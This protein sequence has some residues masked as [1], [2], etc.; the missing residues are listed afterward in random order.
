MDQHPTHLSLNRDPAKPIAITGMAG[1]F[2]SA[3]DIT[4]FQ[5]ALHAGESLLSA[6]PPGRFSWLIKP[7]GSMR[8]SAGGFLPDVAAFDAE[9]FGIGPREALRM[10]P[11]LRILLET[12]RDALQDAGLRPSALRGSQTAVF[13]ANTM[14][15]WAN[16]LCSPQNAER[17]RLVDVVPSQL[18]ARISRNFDL[19]GSS[20]VISTACSGGLHAVHRACQALREGECD[21]AL[22]MGVNI[23]LASE[24][25]IGL[26]R[27]GMLARGEQSPAFSRDAAGFLRGE[28]AGV[29]VLMRAGDAAA[30]RHDVKALIRGSSVGHGGAT[31][32]YDVRDAETQSRSVSRALRM[33]G[34]MPRDVAYVELQ[35]AGNLTEEI[36]EVAVIHQG[37]RAVAAD[38]AGMPA[39]LNAGC[40]KPVTGHMEAASGIAQIVKVI[41]VLE[42]GHAPPLPGLDERPGEMAELWPALSF[43]AAGEPLMSTPGQRCALISGLG[44]GGNHAHVVL[45]VPK[46]QPRN[47]PKPE[48]THAYFLSARSSECL[49]GLRARLARFLRETPDLSAED[50]SC[51]MLL[52]RDAE[53]ERA[54]FLADSLRS[55]ASQLEDGTPAAQGRA[56]EVGPC[57]GGD[58]HDRQWLRAHL[59][60]GNWHKLAVLWCQGVNFAWEGVTD[61]LP[62]CMVSLPP[63]PFSR[64]TYWL[65][66]AAPVAVEPAVSVPEDD[67]QRRPAPSSAKDRVY[68]DLFAQVVGETRQDL[69]QDDTT[70]AEMGFDSL[71]AAEL[72]SHVM[73]AQE[74]ARIQLTDII[75]APNLRALID[76]MPEPTGPP[77]LPARA[78]DE[79][80]RHDPFPVTDIQLAYLIGR[81]AVREGG[82]FGCQV[83]W[84]FS[85]PGIDLDRLRGACERLVSRHD[86]LRAV[87]MPD[88][89]QKVMP[90]DQVTSI[91]LSMVDWSDLNPADA[92][93]KRQALAGQ[94]LSRNFDAARWPLFELVVSRGPKDDRLHLALDLLIADGPSLILMLDDL[95]RFY[96]GAEPADPPPSFQFRDYVL[97]TRGEDDKARAYWE[98]RLDTLPEAPQLPYQPG[99]P[100]STVV[101]RLERVLPP[102]AWSDFQRHA[103]SNGLTV[104]AALIA[105]FSGSLA[106]WSSHSS[107]CLNVTL[108]ARKP[109]HP[110]VSRLVGDFTQNIL[111]AVP[112]RAGDRFADYAQRIAAQLLADCEH[113]DFSAVS[114][115]RLL[116]Q[117]HRRPVSMPIVFTSLLGYGGILKRKARI[118][119]MGRYVRGATRTPQV[120][121]DAQVLEAEDGLHISWDVM[122]GWL[123]PDLLADMF[124]GFTACTERLATEEAAWQEPGRHPAPPPA[125]QRANAT[126]ARL[127]QEPIHAGILRQAEQDPERVAVVAED[128][129]LSFGELAGEARCLAQR[130]TQHGVRHG[131]L[132][133]VVCPKGWRQ[134]VSVLAAC[135][136]GA[137]YVPVELPMPAERIAKVLA[138]AGTKVVLAHMAPDTTAWPCPVIDDWALDTVAHFAPLPVSATDLAYVIYTSGSTGEPKGVA[139]EHGAV[140]N[141]LHSVNDAFAIGSEDCVLG[142]SSL[143]FDLSV[144]DIFGVLGAGGR[145]VLPAAQSLRDPH[146]LSELCR[147]EG[148]TVWNS[149]PSYL[150]LVVETPNVVLHPTLRLVM[151]SGDWIPLELARGLR[152]QQPQA[153]LVSLGG[154]TEAAIWSIWHEVGEV[155]AHW[156]SIPYGK[157]M[158]NQRFHILDD[159]LQPVPVGE[160]GQLHISG[161][162]LAR[163]YWRDA[164]QTELSFIRHPVTGERLYRT[165]DFGRLMEDGA[166]EF[167]GRRDAQVKIGGH[168]IELGEIEA[169]VSRL[170]PERDITDGVAFTFTDPAGNQRLGL[171]YRSA[172]GAAESDVRSAL[173]ARLAPYMVPAVILRLNEIPLTDNSKVD[174]KTLA[175]MA[176]A[177]SAAPAAMAQSSPPAVSQ[178]LGSLLSDDRLLKSPEDRHAFVAGS[179]AVR[180]DLDGAP[181]VALAGGPVTDE[182]LRRSTRSFAATALADAHLA[183]LLSP[184]R[185]VPDAAGPRRR[186][187]SAGS[188]Y[189]V[190]AYVILQG[191]GLS[192]ARRGLWYYDPAQNRLLRTGDFACDLADLHAPANRAMAGSA[193]VTILLVGDRA[194]IEPL[195]GA[196]SDDMMRIEAGSMAQLLADAAAQ[197]NIGQCTV[198]WM[199]IAPLASGLRLSPRHVLLYALLAGHPASTKVQQ[200]A[201]HSKPPAMPKPSGHALARVRAAWSQVL[202]H[203]QFGDD[204]NF[205][206]VGGNSFVAVSLQAQLAG[207]FTPAPSVTDLFRYPTVR[208][209]AAHLEPVVA[210]VEPAA[211]QPLPPPELSAAGWRRSRRLDARRSINGRSGWGQQ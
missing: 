116:S 54:V 55:L 78:A 56:A 32:S 69:W 48:A 37:F 123:A 168:R 9:A 163:C 186:Y 143:A 115:M 57:I 23:S 181:A 91:P 4:S 200:P 46:R 64:Q 85:H 88:A 81:E 89:T 109:L 180:R 95:A 170:I 97:A 132:V 141:T 206:E 128:R 157:A 188:S 130:L 62:G 65:E 203:E 199:D 67:R 29:L 198:G 31:G 134:I 7:T 44:F 179:M 167:L 187:A 151:L 190:Q 53:A 61:E 153:R 33:A 139:L 131:D 120:L 144:W 11:Q 136:C 133:G 74:N 41:T 36:A 110:D 122:E 82:G 27:A 51:T 117:K 155:P 19:R 154:A 193:P 142:V 93:V 13:L 172:S 49:G 164:G 17:L 26:A 94:L 40:L 105:A 162:G 39:R 111:L 73:A 92:E 75:S 52:G 71:A 107:F 1:R 129:R 59:R 30:G 20:E 114:V 182:P 207:T 70:T 45:E 77:A 166:I 15:D 100:P 35:A 201:Q 127:P 165:G 108:A 147:R 38:D 63:T 84:E 183:G 113:G 76:L 22:V 60:T 192:A 87:F 202:G 99:K 66:D 50:I 101:R 8:Q 34:I 47:A 96:E 205:F 137:A 25:Y 150:R 211:P 158:P 86:M 125:L 209:L 72:R 14:N 3:T 90:P 146:Y 161:T 126:A 210:A 28:G 169:A 102:A 103:A 197:M 43:A 138:R 124:A 2:A 174:R 189:A 24:S 21:I 12:T 177:Q 176:L 16:R 145:L 58:E 178:K 171:C 173:A 196:M 112:E 118:D 152:R 6:T 135:L 121:L 204:A 156:R 160:D 175:R 42:A 5:R 159:A 10:D 184:L 80:H 185:E 18:A 148:V 191:Q 208:E 194:A 79:A 195:Y 140:S 68:R 149:T 98:R 104:N 119:A 106:H 83:H